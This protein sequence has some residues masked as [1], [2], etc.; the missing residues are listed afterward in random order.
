MAD[1]T[2]PTS[3]SISN[4][5]PRYY[6][7]DANKK[8]LQ[9]T[10][11]QLT[12]SGKVKKI[13]GYLGKRNAKA[14]TGNDIF[15]SDV[16]AQREN[17]QLEPGLVIKDELDNV[18]FFKDYQ[19][20]INQLGV[21]GSNTKNH[22]RLNK[23]EFYSWNPHI[24]WDKFVNF[25]Q[26]YWLPYGPNAITIYGQQRAIASTYTVTWE[27]AI[28]SKEFLFTPNG[29]T[30]NPT[31]KLYRGQTYHFEID[32]QGEP[33]SIKTAR[34]TGAIDRYI[35]SAAVDSFAVE[36]GT[37]TFAVPDNAPN[38]LY[39]VS[40]NDINLGGVFHILDIKENTEINVGAEILG[41]KTY[42]LPTGLQLSNGM[43]V[44]FGGNV[45]PESYAEGEYYV[46]G[47]GIGI[48]LVAEKDLEVIFPYTE[49]LSV[50]W[51]DTKFDTLPFG[52]ASAYAGK[53]DYILINR[54]SKDKNPWSRYNRWFHQDVVIA[55]AEYNGNVPSLS[56]TARAVR[57]IIEFD[58]NLKLFNFGLESGPSVDLI[59]TFTTDVFSTIE[60]TEGYNI[61][62]I[63]LVEGHRILV[64]A[65]ADKMT[66]NKVYRVHFI[67]IQDSI[68]EKRVRQLH[69]VLES[70]PV[71]NQVIVIKS[72]DTHQG[73]MYWFNGSAWKQAQTKI[74]L[75]QTPLFDVVD[76]NGYSFGDTTVYDGST[77]QGTK[78]FSYKVG[79][80]AVD[81]N[82]GFALSYKNI[83][84]TGDILFNFDAISD[85][86]QYKEIENILTGNISTGYFVRYLGNDKV[87]YDN[88]WET[89]TVDHDYQPAIRIY[90]NSNQVNNFDLDI[91]DNKE[92]L[93]DLRARIY[94]NGIRLDNNLWSIIDSAVY[95]KI[96]LVN[97]I[98]LT[99]ILTIKAFAKQPINDNG[100]YEIPI[101]LQNNPLNS[102]MVD[103]TLGEVIDHVNSIVEN[104]DKFTGSFPGAN[105]LRDLGNV[106]SQ[107]TKFVQ[108]SGPLSLSLYH[109]TST[110]NNIV[111]ALEKAR[112]DYGSFKRNFITVAQTLGIDTAPKKFVDLIL[113]E[114]NKDKPK[115][116][117]YY[118]SDMAPFSSA[119][120]NDYTVI[121]YRIKTYPL[122]SV[123][124]LD[125]LSNTAVGVYVNAVQILYGRDYTFN[126]DGF[127]VINSTLANDDVVTIYEYDNTDGC[128]I[129]ATPTKLG[130]WPKYE[131]K[132]YLDT[133]L[134][135]PRTMIQGHDGS[136]VLAYGD[137]RDDL[138]LELEKRIF[139]NIKVEYNPGI[140]DVRDVIPGYNRDNDY[141]ITEFNEV[142]APS[143][144]KWTGFIDRDFTKPL[145][146]DKN[147]PLTF[148]YRGHQAPDGRE[149]PGYWRGIYR[150]LFDTDRPNLCPWE[151]LGFNAQPIWWES[152]YG[153][154][155]YTSDNKILWQDLSEGIIRVPGKPVERNPKYYRPFLIDCIPVDA[156]GNIQSP[157]LSNT[158]TGIITTSSEGDFIFGDVSPIEAAWRRSSYFPFSV[159][160]ASVLLTPAR[161]IGLTFDRS[162]IVRN[163]T[164]QLVYKETNLRITPSDI[165]IPNTYSSTSRVATAG[166]VNYV[167]D[168]IL[169]DNL[170]SYNQYVYDLNNINFNLS[171][172]IGG[173]TSKEKFNLLLDSKSPT[174]VGGVFI[175]QE[176]YKII[177]NSSSPVKK[178]T[179]SGVIVTKLQDGF[180]IKGYS[181]TQPYFNYY[182]WV[183]SGN[184][185]NVGGISESFL[186][187]TANERYV[188]GKIAKY[189]GMYYRTTITH[190]SGANFEV[191]NFQKLAELPIIGGRNAQLRK[192]WDRTETILVP[193]GTKFRTIQEVVDFLLGYGEYLKDQGFIFDDFNN[194]M[195][196]ISN[197]ETS[198]KE[199][200]FWTTQNWSSGQDKWDDW[201][202]DQ[203]V[204][205][206]AIIR[207]NGDYYRALRNV[208]VSPIFDEREYDKLE[209]LSTVGSSVIS[210]SPSAAKITIKTDYTVIDDILNSFNGYE[211]FNVDGTKIEPNFLDSY[212]ENNIVSYTPQNTEGL[213]GA[214]FFLVQKEQVLILDN[215]TLFNDTIYNLES[216]YRQERIKTSSYVSM[217]WYGGFDV[218]GFV[219]DQAKIQIWNAWTDYALGDTVKYKEFYYG[220]KNSVV[221]TAEFNSDDWY[222]L[223]E[224]PTPRLMPNWTY[225]ASQ[226]E[227]FFSLDSG[228]FDVGQ[229]KMAQ[230]YIGYQKRQYLDNIIQ[231]DVSEFKFYQGMI[232]EKGTQ[233]VLNKLFD[234]LSSE[235][236]ESLKFYEEWAIRVGQYGATA[237]FEEIEFILDHSKFKNNPQGFELVQEINDG[238][239]DF[240]IRQ[241]PNDIYLKPLGY[242]NNPWPMTDSYEQYLRTP[243]YVRREDAT[244]VLGSISNITTYSPANLIEGDYVWCAFEGKEWN[245]YRYTASPLSI[246]NITYVGTKLTVS[247]N[248]VVPYEIGTYIAI[249]RVTGAVGF[250]KITSKTNEKFTA[251]VTLTTP[252]VD[253]F[254]E[255]SV[256]GLFY[257][258]SVRTSSI[259]N[260]NGIMPSK[261]KTAEKIWTDTSDT[262]AWA[263]WEHSN[264]YSVRAF[265]NSTPVDN[266]AYGRAIG[267]ANSGY[268]AVVSTNT[269]IVIAYDRVPGSV[270][271]LQRQSVFA[272]DVCR[273]AD[274]SSQVAGWFGEVIAIT[275]NSEWI[276]I[277]SPQVSRAATLAGTNK[278]DA[279]GVN[280]GLTKQGVVS[281]YQKD[282]ANTM[283]YQ[284]SIVSPVP[285]NNEYFG[286]AIV[287]T[288]DK[289]IVSGKTNTV[290]V[291]Q[292]RIINDNIEWIYQSAVNGSTSSFGYALAVAPNALV[293]SEPVL[294]KVHIHNNAT[295]YSLIV[296]LVKND[297]TGFGENVTIS[298]TG[299][300]IAVGTKLYDEGAV[301][302]QGGVLVYKKTT[303]GTYSST[304]FQVIKSPRPEIA[305]FFGSKVEF[306]NN[307]KTLAIFS[308]NGDSYKETTHDVYSK[309]LAAA[310][311]QYVNDPSSPETDSPTT[312][313]SGSMKF[314]ELDI[315]SG[316]VDVFDQ[317]NT[318]WTYSESLELDNP[319][320]DQYGSGFSVGNNTILIGAPYADDRGLN[321]GKIYSYLKES[322]TFSWTKVQSQKAKPDVTKIKKA[323]LYN[324][325]TNKLLNYIDVVD[326]IQG[327]I[328][329]PADQEIKFKEFFD[330]AVYSVGTDAVVIDDGQEWTDAYV[331]MLWWDLNTAKFIDA[332]GGDVVYR[333]TNWNTLFA[334][335]S[336]DIYEWVSTSLLPDA[337]D[338][339]ADTQAGL[340]Q[341][342][343]GISLYGSA[344][345]SIKK[346]YDSVAQK[347]K[348]TYYYWVKNKR[349]IPNAKGR[350]MAASD[351]SN[352]ISNPKG[353]GYQYLALTASNSFSLVNVDPVLS[354]ADVVLGIQYWTAGQTDQNIHSEWKLISEDPNTSLP[355]AIESKWFDSLC[356]KDEN[357][358][359]VP[360]LQLPPKLRYGIQSR[361]RQSMFVNR[362]ETLK[363]FVEQTN[364]VL[365]ANQIVS[366]R[367]ITGLN[368][369][370]PEPSLVTGLYDTI[371]DT[372]AE[373]RFASVSTVRLA[374]IEA[375]VVDGFITGINII[376]AGNG[377]ITAPYIKVIGNGENAV[378]KAIISTKGQITG[379]TVINKG[380][381]YDSTTQLILRNY[382]VLVHSDSQA[383]GRWSIYAYDPVNKIWSRS[384]TQAYDTRKYWSYA[385]WYD[386]GVS[387]FTTVDYSVDTVGDLAAIEPKINQL[388]KVRTS[389]TSGWLLLQKYADSTSIDWTQIYKVI[390]SQNGTVQLNDT[391]YKF[392]DTTL[393]FD[394]ALFDS[395]TFDNTAVTELRVILNSL[396][397]DILI[398]TLKEN[399]LDLFFVCLRNAF[400][401]QSYIDW[402]FKTSFVRAQHNVGP[403]KEKVTYNNDNLT[404]YQS[405]IEE[406]KPYR[407]KI[408]EY[409]SSY[410]NIDTN[411]ASVT[412]F[413]ILPVRVGTQNQSI[414]ITNV[415]GDIQANLPEILEYPWKHWLDNVGF[416][417]T[418][419]VLTDRGT[420]Y[421]TEPVVTI[422]GGYGTGATA[423]AFIA[424]GKVNRIL[425]LTKGSGYLSAP[426]VVINGGFTPE[427]TRATA[428]SKIGNSV[429]R[430]NFIKIKFDRVS[431]TYFIT[432]L[433]ETELFAGTGSQ[434]QF[435]LK[436]G[437]DVRIGKSRVTIDGVEVLRD[438]YILTIAT[439]TSRGYTSY[440]GKLTFKSAPAK[441][442]AISITY[443]KDWSLLTAADRI[444]YYYNPSTGQAG[445]DLAQLMTGV[446]YGGVV[447]TG[448]DF[449][450]NA[451]WDSLPYFSDAW[452]SIDPTFDDYIIRA[453]LNSNVFELPYIPASG[454]QINIYHNGTRIDD[455][456]FGTANPVTN[457]NA[458][459]RT[460]IGNG[461]NNVITL[462]SVSV[463]RTVDGAK[464]IGSTTITL[465]DVAGIQLNSLVL[466]PTV[467]QAGTTVVSR[468]GL[469]AVA[470][471]T[472]SL[473]GTTLT[474]LGLTADYVGMKVT[475]AGVLADTY[476][477][478]VTLGVQSISEVQTISVSGVATTSVRF[479]GTLIPL[480]VVGDTAATTVLKLVAGRET[481][482][483]NWNT[484][485]ASREIENIEIDF[486]NSG[487]G[488]TKLKITYKITEG[489]VPAIAISI[490]AGVTFAESVT[491][492]QGVTGVVSTAQLTVSQPVISSTLLTYIPILTISKS[493]LSDI[494][495][496]QEILFDGGVQYTRG[497]QAKGSTKIALT[498]TTGIDIGALL[499]TSIPLL[500]TEALVI[501]TEVTAIDT[502]TKTIT[503]SNPLDATLVDG[504]GL[505]FGYNKLYFRKSTSDGSIKPLDTD[506]DTSVTG[507]DLAYTTAQGIAADDIIMDGDGFVTPTTSP[508]T[509]EVVP[510]QITDAVAIKVFYRPT[511]GSAQ[512]K[513]DNYIANGFRD[514]FPITQFPNSKQAVVVKVNN[515][516]LESSEYEID[517]LGKKVILNEI[518]PAE[519]FVS[520]FSF[521]FNGENV[522]DIDYFVGDGTTTEFIT[523]APY[524]SIYSSLVY[525][526]GEPVTY[527]TF[528]T[529]ASYESTDKIGIRFID[530]PAAGDVINYVIVQST[531]Q[532]FATFKSESLSPNGTNRIFSLQNK[533][534]TTQPL[535][536]NIFVRV[537]QQIL[538][539]A[540][541]I[542]F[543]INRNKLNYV[544]DKT[545]MLPYEPDT[546]DFIVYADTIPLVLGRD[547]SID[548]SGITVTINKGIYATYKN[549]TLT[550][551]ISRG[552][553]YI[554]NEN[555]ITFTTAPAA[556]ATVE[557]IS[558]Y[559]HNILDIHRTNLNI[560]PNL[561]YDAD[562][563]EYYDYVGLTSG[564]IVLERSVIAESYVWV[565]K[566]NQL[567]TPSIDFKLNADKKSIQLTLVPTVNDKFEVI[568]YSNN[569]HKG[570][571]SYMQFKDMLNRTHFKRLP[572]KKQTKLKSNLHYYDTVIELEDAS[573]F[574]IPNPALNRPGIIEIRGERIEYLVKDGNRLKQL[575]RS[576]LGT[577]A[578]A[579]HNAGTLVQD[580]G[581]SET[582]PYQDTVSIERLTSDG[583]KIVTTRDLVEKSS[584]TWNFGSS[585]VSSIPANYGQNNT[586]EVFVGGYDSGTVWLP[587][588]SYTAG[589]IVTVGSYLYRA[590]VAHTSAATFKEDSSKWQFFIGNI[591]L[592][593]H[594]F[595]VYNVNIHPESP[596]GDIQM[597]PDFSVN[598]TTNS[599]RLTN[600]LDQG[601]IITVV[602]KTGRLW[603]GITFNPTPLT[604]DTNSLIIDSG[605]TTI[606]SR[607][608]DAALNSNRQIVEFISQ[609]PGI[610]PGQQTYT[611]KT[612]PTSFDSD[613]GTFDGTGGTFDR[614]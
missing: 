414:N 527:E 193:Y 16:S 588:I 151:M 475:G 29:L 514:E 480:S 609:E 6:R 240:I 584:N 109:T 43:K 393:G 229:Q 417:V 202:A 447:V 346:Q 131:P 206:G 536:N 586:L 485:N 561:T 339:I 464:S 523:K 402:A 567:L 293:I 545:H 543:K 33:F 162:R 104:T 575:R 553:D 59:D 315:D 518:K 177:L 196:T 517:Y 155:P 19:D 308:A 436:W 279:L 261:F 316:R 481:I 504:V 432:E 264:V 331:G 249:V 377:Y 272:P 363:Q 431:Q 369:F 53:L 263:V 286:S 324:K 455:L 470:T 309:Q 163:L 218:P 497:I 237:A 312:F 461:T 568:T 56:Q 404:D 244:L 406:V 530:T 61:D 488:S 467:I 144:F 525:I 554:C 302:D 224:E 460:F 190:S 335:S 137:Y 376:D 512:I 323:F 311:S 70:N 257:L 179:Y 50:L 577:G 493:L 330:P 103:F 67:N 68:K 552:E 105:N 359:E 357:N 66:N 243:G 572:L 189:N 347:F 168:Y 526:N 416:E 203:V 230:H 199:F 370:D 318:K 418:D 565:T 356:G 140:F 291:F 483:N 387:Q 445:K 429:I 101:N 313:D 204:A 303:T 407:T 388:V 591:R 102:A 449:S 292:K 86:F 425:L 419:L 501:N 391:L 124:T 246:T 532:T 239:V 479:L 217:G 120:Q 231:D 14:A 82:L 593:K 226:F 375:I 544:I 108:H 28:D 611:I 498:T 537:N 495:D 304:P 427:G 433:S 411:Q 521:G 494:A 27:S 97:D 578:P 45:L 428:I 107:G 147:N 71:T 290:Y 437:P 146:Y 592:K 453:G 482:I 129:P 462:P 459:V 301:F 133:T 21:F 145:S 465:Q 579:M 468:T 440:Y 502:I 169:S 51:D 276:A 529:D 400:T 534:G 213:F 76:A 236:K 288:D 58:A 466:A 551:V 285:A 90:K 195:A 489:N 511:T 283:V 300:Y 546:T 214:T 320:G 595:K 491:V 275:P 317:Y 38:V 191:A 548:I 487:A 223:N 539:P 367:D 259:D 559:Q 40:E 233:N 119:K 266:G 242:N 408:R 297:E 383:L 159:L 166:L 508:A 569:I 221:G 590:L 22:N 352:L 10:L 111:K 48:Q 289:M 452:D 500:T 232:I 435:L 220:A 361:P 65:D 533:I 94:I 92:N 128:F 178:L 187:W 496:L 573:K 36:K 49:E 8:F 362:F 348:N 422:E 580:I 89:S 473:A 253:P 106:S 599:L 32:S 374:V 587:G 299:E 2:N 358:R 241:T 319:A 234:V 181:K 55:S 446:D 326:P 54:A 127:V 13:N 274:R 117:A 562:S 506:Y 46:E 457:I 154:A 9:A 412:D 337:W 503:L 344:V 394:G 379:V 443:I 519:T 3:D 450:I 208:P 186:N 382:S 160:L 125:K 235:D 252:P 18:D 167:V 118:F 395:D 255:Q 256:A 423:R 613:G 31:L 24:D 604:L 507:G 188:V 150:W 542:Y 74:G 141:S 306:I 115:T 424:N 444:Q 607:E 458:T 26:Y 12:K 610:W 245:I 39:Y 134:V 354:N 116:G 574:D 380:R 439:S 596:D 271:W 396:K 183:Q 477:T 254:N 492:V 389:G 88:G 75:N 41:K 557:I 516:I 430:S 486:T 329:G 91:F 381:G 100:Y 60:G 602:K 343:S 555:T 175:P 227:D 392:A 251:T 44:R 598:G 355:A 85:S 197:W 328:P 600:A 212:R 77:F 349:T 5:L 79:T 265:T 126:S 397:N 550:V 478:S 522:L 132:I 566:N 426:T 307:G 42:K 287:M 149:T 210:L 81:S 250:Y 198:V 209:G 172:R 15:V 451:G 110:S 386:T 340:V 37:V 583:T 7:S 484:A 515:T 72:G 139:N 409:V 165:L 594:P 113:L 52:S 200:L 563:I 143:F 30:R 20:Y 269:N 472:G 298:P 284:Y 153:P 247:L 474:M 294:G 228:N 112:D 345:Y 192:R 278:T 605:T 371:V 47:V 333:N 95:K 280:S 184:R 277:G 601:T 130:I 415:A 156:F 64:A 531:Q 469:R 366:T 558:S 509:E 262:D 334:T 174:A 136:L 401:E 505:S 295:G 368:S 87:D 351:V 454:T 540:P 582:I 463:T 456:N 338:K 581:P 123:F 158:A 420:D 96:V 282:S 365:L 549:K 547:F 4:F 597:D 438:N 148:N 322:G 35:A 173:F 25:Q 442:T 219:F 296:T 353:Q 180:E 603:T 98:A 499:S 564:H 260:A 211:M 528:Q 152:L 589:I 556:N 341:G 490:N 541:A 267:L 63:Q 161:T 142:L 17:Y 273:A 332:Y 413:D 476:I 11:D 399:Y 405:Y 238:L 585:F 571:I 342:I 606:D 121:D 114:I 538:K 138:I 560:V 201:S 524:L 157:L 176:N 570:T 314:L 135:T 360:D 372:D 73:S 80:G 471:G 336:I 378:L 441:N 23:Q 321:S 513:V 258:K 69:L 222:K 84:N 164:G 34:S 305:G 608:A 535:A 268:F 248:Q 434:L 99:D 185:I 281:L 1:N 93:L 170:K 83:N 122:S 225:K 384:Q 373:L 385:D 421:V 270:S 216:G 62:G 576:T 403:L 390:G 215:T 520:I 325:K 194:T 448:L 182:A 364:T 612:I 350:L 205:Y 57:P 410:S 78:L 207:Y 310:T 327:K 614:G 398:D 510:G 171:Y